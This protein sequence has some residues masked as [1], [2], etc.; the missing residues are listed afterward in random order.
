MVAEFAQS[1]PSSYSADLPNN[2]HGKSSEVGEHAIFGPLSANESPVK[3]N[4]GRE[5]R[6]HDITKKCH[7][8]AND[9]FGKAMYFD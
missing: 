7:C 6:V 3:S 4:H 8:F 1:Q 9:S 5:K 2:T